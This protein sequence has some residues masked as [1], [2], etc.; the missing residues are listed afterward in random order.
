MLNPALNTPRLPQAEDKR[1]QSECGNTIAFGR[2]KQLILDFSTATD[3]E[4]SPWL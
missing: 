3:L 2:K 1:A 4:F